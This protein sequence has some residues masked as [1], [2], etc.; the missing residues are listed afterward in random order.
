VIL[1][2]RWSDIP[3]TQE[4]YPAI[5]PT[6]SW[7]FAQGWCADHPLHLGTIRPSIRWQHLFAGASH[8]FPNAS[9]DQ[10]S[11]TAFQ[12]ALAD[13][14]RGALRGGYSP[15]IDDWFGHLPGDVAKWV[16]DN[17]KRSAEP[18]ST[19]VINKLKKGF[20]MESA[21]FIIVWV[22]SPMGYMPGA[23]QAD[24]NWTVSCG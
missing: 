4:G 1:Q 10:G 11:V 7:E 6:V 2:L 22:L 3:D 13:F 5:D 18:A 9:R 8:F 17:A 20:S 19:I 23:S 15:V 24:Y 21:R 14:S 12:A 16:R